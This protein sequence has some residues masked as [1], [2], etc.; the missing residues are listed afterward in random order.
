[1]RRRLLLV[2]YID[3]AMDKV[4]KLQFANL[5]AHKYMQNRMVHNN[6]K[7]IELNPFFPREYVVKV[8]F[9]QANSRLPNYNFNQAIPLELR[10]GPEISQE[11]IN[12][13]LYGD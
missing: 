1:M 7:H 12:S 8:T 3:K 13:T 5:R 9:N 2:K 4:L 11:W 10:D 6:N